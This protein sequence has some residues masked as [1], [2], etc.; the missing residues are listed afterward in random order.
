MEKK[1]ISLD[2]DGTLL[3]KDKSIS[4]FS[5][6]VI[7]KL[8]SLGHIVC[9]STGRTLNTSLY[10]YKLLNLDTLMC[11]MEGCLI[12]NPSLDKTLTLPF[13]EINNHIPNAIKFTFDKEI[14]KTILLRFNNEILVSGNLTLNGIKIVPHYDKKIIDGIEIFNEEKVDK[15][16]LD[17]LL[18]YLG[19]RT[20]PHYEADLSMTKQDATI[21]DIDDDVYGTLIMLNKNANAS[22][23]MKKIQSEFS[24]LNVTGFNGKNGYF[25]SITSFFATKKNALRYFC[26]YYGILLQDSIVFG[27]A[28]NDVG[29]LSKCKEFNG[30][31]YAMKNASDEVKQS[32][33]H[34]TE[35]DNDNDGVAKELNKIFEL[36]IE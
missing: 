17:E 35:F 32:A 6:K 11:N 10:Y 8:T 20:T 31:A 27:D 15:D 3:K 34:I 22:E 26:S 13:K 36:G 23:I 33:N 7:K 24:T 19:L 12:S 1:L 2:L 5:I 18:I 14:L 29:A 30:L 28:L 25:I 9:L 21:N 16:V 4:E